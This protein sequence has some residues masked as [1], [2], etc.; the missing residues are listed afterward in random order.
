MGSVLRVVGHVGHVDDAGDVAAAVADEDADARVLLADVALDGVFGL[1]G[2]RAA[3]V[4]ELSHHG[5]G[6]CGRLGDRLGDVLGL[7]ERAG[8]EDALAAGLQRSELLQLAEAMAV[9]GNAEMAGGLLRLACRFKAGREHHHVVARLVQLAGLVFPA[10]Q[11]V[12][13]Q[14]ILLDVGGP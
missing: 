4:G 10:D 11:E 9:E 12:V 6:S 14:R 5:G 8:D 7:A 2:E 3:R 1:D 13:G